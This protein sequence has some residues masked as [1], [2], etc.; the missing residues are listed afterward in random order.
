MMLLFFENLCYLKV[1]SMLKILCLTHHT[2]HESAM[3][4]DNYTKYYVRKFLNLKLAEFF[5]NLWMYILYRIF[6]FN[7]ITS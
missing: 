1:N 4:I 6:I 3:M 2:I 7:L 5:L